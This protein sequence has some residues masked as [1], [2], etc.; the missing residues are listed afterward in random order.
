MA[1]VRRFEDLDIWKDARVIC[2]EIRK[3]TLA[4]D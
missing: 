2:N 4:S 1:T 3:I